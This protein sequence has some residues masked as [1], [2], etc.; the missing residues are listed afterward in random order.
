MH[1]LLLGALFPY[2]IGTVVYVA[3]RCR[4][5]LGMLIAIPLLMGSCAVWAVLPDL[6]RL[7][8]LG[9][10]Y[11]RMAADPRTN[12]FFWHWSID[13]VEAQTVEAFTPLFTGLFVLMV[14]SLLAAAW[15]ELKIRAHSG[16]HT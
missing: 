16:V 7:V 11:A 12:I 10:L 2:L 13:Q 14:G 15:R 5:S 8:G 1:Q 4:A 3:R 9:S 6:P